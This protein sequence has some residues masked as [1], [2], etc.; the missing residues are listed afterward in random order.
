L[1]LVALMIALTL[2]AIEIGARCMEWASARFVDQTHPFVDA[3]NPVPVFE[4]ATVDGVRVMRRTRHHPLMLPGLSFAAEKP[5]NGFRVFLLGGSAAGGWPY[6]LGGFSIADHLRKKLEILYPG[7]AIDVINAAGG[8]YASHRVRFVFDEIIDYDPDLIVLYSGNNEF[9]ENFV[10]RPQLPSGAWKH[11]AVGG[12]GAPARPGPR[13]AQPPDD[14][15]ANK[16]PHPPPP[17][18]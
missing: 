16:H 18:P 13:G 1:L 5:P 6:D 3:Q 8:T 7:H 4:E 2:G 17:P 12:R 14:R 10:F 15:A 11:L 9:L